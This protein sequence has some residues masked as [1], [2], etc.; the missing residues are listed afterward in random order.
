MFLIRGPVLYP[1][2]CD[3]LLRSHWALYAR[4]CRLKFTTKKRNN[5]IQHGWDWKY[6]LRAARTCY[7]F[8]A[9][10]FCANLLIFFNLLIFLR[11]E[12]VSRYLY[13]S[14]ASS[15]AE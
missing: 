7:Y 6:L 13:A 9:R 15:M 12:W 14:A 3:F 1:L 11:G 2:L 4:R 8:Y 10:A 5:K